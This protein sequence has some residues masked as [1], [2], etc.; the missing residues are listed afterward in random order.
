MNSDNQ[1]MPGYALKWDSAWGW[2]IACKNMDKAPCP[3][4]IGAGTI[5]DDDGYDEDGNLTPEY[6]VTCPRCLGK[7]TY[8]LEMETDGTENS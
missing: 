4:C 7:G 2:T 5:T 1:V 8:R 3:Q 6:Q